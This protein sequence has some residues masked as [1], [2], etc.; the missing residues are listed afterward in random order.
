MNI[1]EFAGEQ[2]TTFEV[3]WHSHDQWELVYCTNGEGDFKFQNGM[4]MHYA[5]GD[6]VAIPPREVHCNTSA[7]GFTNVYLRLT[8]P[9]FPYKTTFR[10]ADDTERHLRA[11]FQQVSFY[12]LS[13]IQRSELLLSALGDLIAGYMVVLRSNS[14]FSE[15]VELLRAQILRRYVEPRFPL[16]ECIR[17][18]PF[19]YDYVRK[20]F[21]KEMGLTPL[22]YMTRLRMNKAAT[23]LSSQAGGDYSVAEIAGLCGYDDA[24]YFSRVFRKFYGM[25]PSAYAKSH[26]GAA[27]K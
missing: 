21:K 18:L 24:L 11:A 27:G 19:H 17:R 13:D 9:S 3:R 5:E 22:E 16:D 12:Y 15:P 1:I 7:G 8:D 14:E 20:L 10:V 26:S 2:A 6:T 25:S 4:T 23:M